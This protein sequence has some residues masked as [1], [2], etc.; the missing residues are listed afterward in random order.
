M[1]KKVR[2]DIICD[3]TEKEVPQVY[4]LFITK[5]KSNGKKKYSYYKV[6]EKKN[7]MEEIKE[8]EKIQNKDQVEFF[9]HSQ[10]DAKKNKELKQKIQKWKRKEMLIYGLAVAFIPILVATPPTEYSVLTELFTM[11]ILLAYNV[12]IFGGLENIH[13]ATKVLSLKTKL[14]PRLI[15]LFGYIF[16]A[17]S[18]VL[19]YQ[20]YLDETIRSYESVSTIETE[21]PEMKHLTSTKSKIEK[22]HES[23]QENALIDENK[24][25]YILTL[26]TYLEENPYV[27][28][29]QL[30]SI[31][32]N[33]EITTNTPITGLVS[34]TFYPKLSYIKI[35]DGLQSDEL[36]HELTHLTGSVPFHFLREGVTTLIMTEYAPMTDKI[37]ETEE[38]YQAFLFSRM[39]TIIVGRDAMLQSFSEKNMAAIDDSLLEL[40]PDQATLR[41]LYHCFIEV[42]KKFDKISRYSSL[43]YVEEEKMNQLYEQHYD[44]LEKACKAIEPYEEK[45]KE[46]YLAAGKID[47]WL[48][49]YELTKL[50]LE[51]AMNERYDKQKFEKC[52]KLD[53]K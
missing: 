40:V 17:F 12:T 38:Y 26:D 5:T 16:S 21:T 4:G 39:L 27:N 24:Y 7:Y 13:Q 51:N 10:K 52:L 15:G 8:I 45:R 22:L 33:L 23:L 50:A 31:Y 3:N 25:D 48:E 2:I 11:G 46:A 49:E 9:Y 28:Y 44:A 43:E 30:N 34:G 1:N 19:N 14:N 32:K 37:M 20:N 42:D 41:T 36:F 35:E 18:P 29:E 6:K 53:Q 47:E